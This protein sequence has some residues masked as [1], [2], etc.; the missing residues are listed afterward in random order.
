MENKA[1]IYP[2]SRDS[3]DNKV[4]MPER[5]EKRDEE[6]PKL[7]LLIKQQTSSFNLQTAM[8]PKEDDSDN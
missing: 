6:D 4:L 1:N 3:S 7:N 8:F 2:E 5:V